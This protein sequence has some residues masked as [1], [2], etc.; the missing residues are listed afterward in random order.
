MARPV[1]FRLFGPD[2]KELTSS[3]LVNLE[4]KEYVATF[5]KAV[6]DRVSGIFPPTVTSSDLKVFTNQAAL[7][8]SHS[9]LPSSAVIAALG[10]TESDA[11]AVLAPHRLQ[12][13]LN[14]DVALPVHVD[15]YA[16]VHLV[17][18]EQV[19]QTLRHSHQDE[20]LLKTIEELPNRIAEDQSPPFIVLENSSGM[21]KTQMAFN[22]MA[23]SDKVA[24]HYVVCA[25]DCDLRRE[26]SVYKAFRSRTDAFL[27]CMKRDKEVFWEGSVAGIAIRA[28]TL[29]TFGFICAMVAGKASVSGPKT[30]ADVRACL[31][32]RAK[33]KL[34]CVFF[35]DE[36][37]HLASS[38]P[39]DKDKQRLR[40]MRN[41]FRVFPEI[42]LIT[43]STSGSARNMIVTGKLS[44]GT[45]P[46][47][48]LWCVVH[49]SLPHFVCNNGAIRHELL[50]LLK[51][52]RP[53]FAQEALRYMRNH[54]PPPNG[55]LVAY[56]DTM[57]SELAR[58]F[59]ACKPRVDAFRFGQV[60]LFLATSFDAPECFKAT[61]ETNLIHEHYARLK[62]MGPFDLQIDASGTLAKE[63]EL[64]PWTSDCVFPPP[65]EDILLFLTL[66]GGKYFRA[67]RGPQTEDPQMRT[68]I[69]EVWAENKVS[70][71]NT[72]QISCDGMKLEA[73]VA[74]AV[75]NA[76]HVNGFA[77][78]SFPAFFSALLFDL[79]LAASRDQVVVYPTE[80][81]ERFALKIHIPFLGPPNVEWPHFLAPTLKLKNL[82]RTRNED[83]IDFAVLDDTCLTG[84]CKDY[85][86][87]LKTD[88]MKKVLLRVPSTSMVHLVVA[89]HLEKNGYFARTPCFDGFVNAHKKK[90]E[91]T[92]AARFYRLKT[93]EHQNLKL[94]E[95]TMRKKPNKRAPK[96]SKKAQAEARA[97]RAQAQTRDAPPPPVAKIVIF[98]E[99]DVHAL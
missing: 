27:T 13:P 69:I 4:E 91:W 25:T 20:A 7:H 80:E 86:S 42:V 64:S 84:E 32:A 1:W 54:P 78:Q 63:A 23:R 11:L 35:L 43:S 70:F 79:G 53:F 38:N 26:Q 87:P 62:E 3:D 2:K 50:I 47:K 36:F 39:R 65:E 41:V 29:W 19:A 14:S 82:K 8:C 30:Q 60:C 40:A 9:P 22:L 85:T 49:P 99:V 89:K 81:V 93:D 90:L 45:G 5:R 83:G 75:A 73:L 18:Y 37:P 59:M 24:V 98:L 48:T 57:A 55:S 66:A 33:M 71:A 94:V 16:R 12:D 34:P 97:A 95:I 6:F 56:L 96:R 92:P 74:A 76:S 72:N 17:P 58:K 51:H 77:G 10:Q 21:G 67:L 46:F 68:R 44:R 15:E 31:R 61:D 52:S 88:T 28:T